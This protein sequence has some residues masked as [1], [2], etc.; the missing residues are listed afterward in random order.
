M[1]YLDKHEY[2]EFVNNIAE[3]LPFTIDPASNQR[4]KKWLT[5]R[6]ETFINE[7]ELFDVLPCP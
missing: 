7:G 3:E 4:S 2:K 1:L 5:S 6:G